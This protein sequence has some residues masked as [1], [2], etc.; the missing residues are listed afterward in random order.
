MKKLILASI[1]SL[2]AANAIAQAPNSPGELSG[3]KLGLRI[4]YVGTSSDLDD[5]FGGGLNLAL[6]F[7]QR[8]RRLFYIDIMLGALYM[9]ENSERDITLDFFG[10][11]TDA[12]SIRVITTTVAPLLELPMSSSTDAYVSAGIGLYTVSVLL[13]SGFFAADVTDN[14]FGVNA[15]A[16]AL[17][18]LSDRWLLDFNAQIHRFWTPD[19]PQDMFYLYSEGDRNPL[20]Y[21]VS[22]GVM[23]RLD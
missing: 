4:G 20:F 13:E 8:I 2:L 9:G 17:Y 1:I 19:D 12:A 10:P 14:H 15:G 16:G 11:G 22:V 18:S 5:N 6:H 7:T 23:I 3:E 21:S